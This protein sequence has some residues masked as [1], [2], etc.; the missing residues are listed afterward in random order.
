[1]TVRLSEPLIL[2]DSQAQP[3]NGSHGVDLGRNLMVL[4]NTFGWMVAAD[5][6]GK[7][8]EAQP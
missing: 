3:G 8:P 4:N 6:Q 5:N 1:V 2:N 7:P